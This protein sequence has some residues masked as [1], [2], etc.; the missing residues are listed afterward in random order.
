[1]RRGLR[2]GVAHGY[3]ALLG[4]SLPSGGRAGLSVVRFPR[5]KYGRKEGGGSRGLAASWA[6]C[7]LLSWF[8]L[9]P[10]LLFL[11]CV[12]GVRLSP[13]SSVLSLLHSSRACYSLPKSSRSRR[14]KRWPRPWRAARARRRSGPRESPVTRSTTRSFSPRSSTID[15]S[16]RCPR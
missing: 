13:L 6:L 10:G 4:S 16:R 5:W 14:S 15:S 11:C 12:F 2:G 3:P 7:H 8:R 1:M 9:L